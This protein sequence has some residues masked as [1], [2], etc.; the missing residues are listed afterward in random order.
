V[1]HEF[2]RPRRAGRK[3][4]EAEEWLQRGAAR[5]PKRVDLLRLVS[6]SSFSKRVSL[7]PSL[8]RLSFCE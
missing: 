1:N 2:S 3:A 5:R 8:Q 6:S 4:E 7:N